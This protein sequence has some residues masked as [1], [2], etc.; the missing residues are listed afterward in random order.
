V[1]SKTHRLSLRPTVA[2]EE[3]PA[4]LSFGQMAGLHEVTGPLGLKSSVALVVD[5]DTHQVLLSKNEH[6]VLPIASLTKLMTGMVVSRPACRW[7]RSSPSRT[8]TSTPRRTAAR[9]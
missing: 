1:A 3:P 6:A 5:Q 7:T 9:A 2:R 4:R 8:R